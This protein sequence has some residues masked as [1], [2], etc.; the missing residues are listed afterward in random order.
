VPVTRKPL[1]FIGSS[2]DDLRAFPDEARRDAGFNLDFVQRA[3][4]PL[5]WKP[6]QIVGPGVKEIRVRDAA[7]VFL[8]W[9][10]DPKASMS[11]TV[12]RRRLRRHVRLTLTWR[13]AA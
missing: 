8:I 2:L 7:G 3:I 12:F 5:N 11:F 4:D 9:R 10:R 6:M 13:L 1:H